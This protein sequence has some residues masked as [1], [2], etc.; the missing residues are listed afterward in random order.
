M[1]PGS[2][3]EVYGACTELR[4][5]CEQAG[6]GY[7]LRVRSPF[8]LTLARRDT[9]TRAQAGAWLFKDTRRWEIRS[10]GTGSKGQRW[11]AWRGWAPPPPGTAC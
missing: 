8:G 6:Q 4:G 11:Y 7:V 10:A 3:D 1:A 9:M 5:L 2:G